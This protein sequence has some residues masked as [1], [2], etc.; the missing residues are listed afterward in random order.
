MLNIYIIFVLTSICSNP[1]EVF[2]VLLKQSDKLKAH[3]FLSI[4]QNLLDIPEDSDTG[5]K[6]WYVV[7]KLVQ[8][9]SSHKESIGLDGK[10]VVLF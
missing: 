3:P 8:Q 7:E 4:L 2:N 9:V 1:N 6:T 10:L 5:M